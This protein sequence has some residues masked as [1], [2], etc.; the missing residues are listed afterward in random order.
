M[1]RKWRI[2]GQSRSHI[3]MMRAEQFYY[4]SDKPEEDAPGPDQ[5][6]NILGEILAEFKLISSALKKKEVGFTLLGSSPKKSSLK[7]RDGVRT[8]RQKQRRLAQAAIRQER[9]VEQ[10]EKQT[11]RLREVE[12]L[13]STTPPKEQVDQTESKSSGS[14]LAALGMAVGAITSILS[15]PAFLEIVKSIFEGIFEGLGFDSGFIERFTHS[16]NVVIDKV[17]LF[18]DIVGG[19]IDIV[20]KGFDMWWTGMQLLIEQSLT[21][22]DEIANSKFGKFMAKH[23]G[24]F[25]PIVE[26]ADAPP[27]PDLSYEKE[28]PRAVE[29]KTDRPAEAVKKPVA[30]TP[31]ATPLPPPQ[32]STP[33]SAPTSEKQPSPPQAAPVE[34]PRMTPRQ[35]STSSPVEGIDVDAVKKMII[36]HEGVR[37]EPYKDSLGL[38]TV[39]VGHLIGDG[40]SL[41]SEWNRKFSMG[42][43]MQLFDKDF[44]KH[45]QAAAKIPG[46]DK[47]NADGKAAFI[48]LTFNMGDTWFKRW[49]NLVKS[50]QAG[51]MEAVAKNLEGSKWATQVKSRAK[52]IV[53]LVRSGG[54][55]T[56]QSTMLAA[57]PADGAA[58]SESSQSVQ[59]KKQRP[60]NVTVVNNTQVNN[61]SIAT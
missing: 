53:S 17:T 22:Y 52:T 41:P 57:A 29:I 8:S 43:V 38:W 30:A 61:L 45:A 20:R 6:K 25:K 16:F 26:K 55:A 56:T 2:P 54:S 58:L 1:A 13:K 4:G 39:G 42:E 28:V 51:D 21:L 14:P 24:I 49:P 37:T 15:G 36:K 12:S 40:K 9:Q 60:R 44:I 34:K 18:K 35:G 5:A 19:A 27:P 31:V 3:E 48:D 59:G 33:P 10:K 7:M 50:L 47:L 11:A 32:I 46:W 23:L